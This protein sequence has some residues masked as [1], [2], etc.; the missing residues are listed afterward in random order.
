M[1]KPQRFAQWLEERSIPKSTGYAARDKGE[2]PDLMY[3]GSVPWV[4]PLSN[5]E[6]EQRRTRPARE[7]R[8]AREAA[9]RA[10]AEVPVLASEQAPREPRTTPTEPKAKPRPPSKGTGGVQ[11]AKGRGAKGVKRTPKRMG[12]RAAALDAE[13]V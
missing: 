1:D 8:E 11:G 7:A 9:A 10:Q 3:I 12:K 6:W 13:A 5:D 2:M 4:T